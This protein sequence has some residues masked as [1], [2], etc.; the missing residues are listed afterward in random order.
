MIVDLVGMRRASG[1]L[2]AAALA[3]VVVLVG[4]PAASAEPEQTG[5]ARTVSVHYPD[6][7]ADAFYQAPPEVADAQPGDVLA[8]RVMPDLLFFPNTEI[9]QVLFRSTNS[10]G[11]PIAATTTIM[12]PRG[13]A[14]G[15]PL[16]SYQHI[17]NGLGTQCLV[18][19]ALYSQDPDNIVRE[20]PALNHALAQG[21]TVAL[22]DHLG[23]TMAYGAAKLGGQITLDGIRA[24]QRA[25]L[26]LQ[27]SP[28]ALAGYSGG[29]M[30]TAWA[31][32]LAPEYAPDLSESIVGVAHGGVP[33][34][35]GAMVDALGTDPHP[36]FGLAMAAAMG[37][38]R[39]YPEQMPLSDKLNTQGLALRENIGN[40]CTNRI[41]VYGAGR[42][43]DQVADDVNFL[44]D[45]QVRAVI[46]ENSLVN[47]PGVPTA[48]VFSWHSSTDPLI[49]VPAIDQ[50]LDW[51]CQAGATV[52]KHNVLAPEHMIAAIE[53]VGPAMRYLGDRFD[54]KPAP[55]NCSGG[56]GGAV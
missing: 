9:S 45:P 29:G 28:V 12:K 49:P 5:A 32:A 11:Q 51:Y 24:A 30:A 33:M 43:A 53:G 20:A 4:A 22:P 10:Q 16:L 1:V 37:L 52:Q 2:G 46:D 27:D 21:W 41:M 34:D 42:S 18:G 39:E 50:T 25:Q 14:A 38:E 8:T 6:P 47:Y 35:L 48:P 44:A 7:P 19:E 23:P 54:G 13:V 3:A 40:G 15:G 17:I 26:G 56:G 31:A 55:S 36:A